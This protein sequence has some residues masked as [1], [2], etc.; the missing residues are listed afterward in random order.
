MLFRTGQKMESWEMFSHRNAGRLHA[1]RSP[2]SIHTNTSIQYHSDI[3]LLD[4]HKDLVH[5]QHTDWE[6]AE[7]VHATTQLTPKRIVVHILRLLLCRAPSQCPSTITGTH[8]SCTYFDHQNPPCI[9]QFTFRARIC[10]TRALVVDGSIAILVC[11][12]ACA[13]R[14]SSFPQ[15]NTQ[16]VRIEMFA[17]TQHSN[18]KLGQTIGHLDVQEMETVVL[19]QKKIACIDGPQWSALPPTKICVMEKVL[20]PPPTTP[21][22]H[23]F[24][25]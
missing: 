25:C 4:Q 10:S 13:L 6:D 23:V 9:L 8:C 7:P 16:T 1:N 17:T 5:W 21:E 15:R 24:H 19:H 11:I 18:L 22:I 3:A 2:G 14:E 20:P 12:E